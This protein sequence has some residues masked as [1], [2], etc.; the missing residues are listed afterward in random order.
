MLK[1]MNIHFNRLLKP[2]VLLY[3]VDSIIW[4]AGDVT[5]VTVLKI[6]GKN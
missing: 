5:M 4:T 3:S 2:F 1:S 6:E